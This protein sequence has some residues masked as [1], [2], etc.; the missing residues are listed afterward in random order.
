M[1]VSCHVKTESF[2]NRQKVKND[3]SQWEM[4][5]RWKRI[6]W[7]LRTNWCDL[8]LRN[9]IHRQFRERENKNCA[10]NETL[11]KKNNVQWNW[12]LAPGSLFTN[13]ST[14]KWKIGLISMVFPSYKTM[15]K[16]HLTKWWRVKIVR[17]HKI[18]SIFTKERI[19]HQ[20][21]N[22]P[23]QMA[24][25]S[26]S[27]LF[28]LERLGGIICFSSL[29]FNSRLT[30]ECNDFVTQTVWWQ[31]RYKLIAEMLKQLTISTLKV[32]A[33]E[34]LSNFNETVDPR[35]CFQTINE[36]WRAV[37]SAVRISDS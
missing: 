5:C 15:Q 13:R 30:H 29:R 19:C 11:Y 3:I 4:G 2:Q 7:H 21:W 35:V 34:K 23:L 33:P 26:Y 12:R 9:G 27:L 14:H 31:K 6:L 32:D 16:F 28:Y 17:Y 37:I 1:R 22:W 8:Y 36:T 24:L 10:N 25:G 18:E 20:K